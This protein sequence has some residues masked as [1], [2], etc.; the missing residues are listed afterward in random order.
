MADRKT[1]QTPLDLALA[2]LP[3]TEAT[4]PFHAH[5]SDSLIRMGTQYFVVDREMHRN[6]AAEE[7]LSAETFAELGR[8]KFEGFPAREEAGLVIEKMG[9]VARGLAAVM[10]K[11][12]GQFCLKQQ[13]TPQAL[14]ATPYNL[15]R[16]LHA[17]LTVF[18]RETAEHSNRVGLTAK[19]LAQRCGIAEPC[20][21]FFLAAGL[22]HDV[23]KL[24]VPKTILQKPSRLDEW[25]FEV[26]RQ[27]A[28]LGQQIL[29]AC[30]ETAFEYDLFIDGPVELFAAC[31]QVALGHHEKPNGRGYPREL[32]GSE[33]S[34]IDR[35]FAVCDVWDALRSE[36]PYKPA[37]S[38]EKATGIINSMAADGDLDPHLTRELLLMD[39]SLNG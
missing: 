12:I 23:G 38:R 25:E 8:L 35:L 21:N 18:D 4:D 3:S 14:A 33:I 31:A 24:C 34:E 29:S 37:H 5:R 26:I 28:G 10:Q 16:M 2:E 30:A 17:S 27:H 20:T 39:D 9:Y 13:T 1:S 36:R 6:P 11:Q 32:V 22:L 7:R 15:A 19:T